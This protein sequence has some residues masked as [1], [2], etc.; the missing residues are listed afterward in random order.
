VAAELSRYSAIVIGPGLG[1]APGTA[2][3]VRG[4]LSLPEIAEVP[5]VVDADALNALARWRGWESEIKAC[6]VLTPHPGELSRMTAESVPDLQGER[7]EAARRY[8]KAWNQ[9]VV[10]K[11]AHTIIS[12]ARLRPGQPFRDGVAGGG[13][14]GDVLAGAIADHRPGRGALGRAALA[15]TCT[16]RRRSFPTAME[17][18]RWRA[19]S[20]RGSR[21]RPRAARGATET[22]RPPFAAQWGFLG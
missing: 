6:A 12:T 4:L 7:L 8:A 16:A 22:W 1:Q 14:D 13:R 2:A 5:V 15:V 18:R 19:S 17:V 9:T 20:A 11:G 10:L 21:G 3:M